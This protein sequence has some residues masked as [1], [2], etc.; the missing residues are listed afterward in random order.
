MAQRRLRTLALVAAVAVSG[1]T[2]AACSRDKK[3]PSVRSPRTTAAAPVTT[4]V[5]DPDRP[6]GGSVRV[7][8]WGA[9]DVGAP[10][11]G[12]AAVRALVL[13]QLF[14]ALPDSTWRP[15][16]VQP[17]SDRTA[18]DARS[19][20][21]KLRP[22]AAWSNGAPITAEDLRRSFDQRVVTA[23]EGPT[24]NGTIT[25]RF[26]QP[27][28]GWRRLWSGTDAVAAPGP[29]IWGGP[30][31]V[32]SS[33]PGLE[34]VLRRNDKWSG[35]VAKGPF[36]DAV[37]LVLVPDP[38]TAAQLLEKGQLDVVMPPAFTVRTTELRGIANVSVDTVERGGWW[39][40]MVLSSRLSEDKRRAMA[41]TV[42]R[43]RFVS[44][45]LQG[46]G[47]VLN[48]FIGP[49]DAAWTGARYPDAGALSGSD[50]VDVVGQIEEPMTPAIQRVVQQRVQ[51]VKGTVELRN[52]EAD[53]V[54][55]WLAAGEYD[56]AIAMFV[57]GPELC[58]LCR[59]G[60]VDEALARAADAGDRSAAAQLEVKLRDQAWVVPYWRPRTTVAWRNG[61][62]GV[63]ANGY[64]LNAAWN[65]WEW[66]R[67]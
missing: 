46:E 37:Q 19:A 5:A 35:V 38:V 30:F 66:W 20:S 39:V 53:R 45:L 25:V 15:L 65:A 41:G 50:A 3:A 9:P 42:N 29:G 55:P 18:R 8:V 23:I 48:G 44:V 54:E 51:V 31:V 28:P 22:R 34:L 67:G 63:R 11:I 16:L 1:T 59:W 36:L 2:L 58:W 43:D 10:T 32:A 61:L 56:A 47:S 6:R 12:G 17:G 13:P 26:N 60:K 33:T 62:N 24:A 40:G 52:A 7:G 27:L 14:A 21:F 4:E 49:E 57:D 64:A